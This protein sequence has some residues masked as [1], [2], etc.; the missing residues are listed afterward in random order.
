MTV[1]VGVF[2]FDTESIIFY[3]CLIMKKLF[4]LLFSITKTISTL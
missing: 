1:K 2:V 4:Y 3:H